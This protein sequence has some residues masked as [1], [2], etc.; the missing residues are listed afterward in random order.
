MRVTS[1]FVNN[2]KTINARIIEKTTADLYHWVFIS[3]YFGYNE[4]SSLSFS[5]S[6][7]EKLNKRLTEFMSVKEKEYQAS[8]EETKLKEIEELQQQLLTTVDGWFKKPSKEI[9]I[10]LKK[11]QDKKWDGISE[12]SKNYIYSE[13]LSTIN[14]VKISKD[15]NNTIYEI[16]P[17]K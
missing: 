10:K 5:G 13:F 4:Y 9:K 6:Q 16:L 14:A 8:F 11:A 3:M 12:W 17:S 15:K 2:M 7:A 1:G